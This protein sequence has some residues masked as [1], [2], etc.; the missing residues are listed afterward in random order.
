MD[1]CHSSSVLLTV[2]VWVGVKCW[3][4]KEPAMATAQCALQRIW[5]R[6]KNATDLKTKLARQGE[7]LQGRSRAEHCLCAEHA[8]HKVRE[9]SVADD[10]R[11]EA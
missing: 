9:T 3:I 6:T 2:G 7:D 5:G 1:M 8:Q 4:L 11:Q 10:L